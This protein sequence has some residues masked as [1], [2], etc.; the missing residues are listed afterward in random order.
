MPKI[1]AGFGVGPDVLLGNGHVPVKVEKGYVPR[2][3]LAYPMYDADYAERVDAIKDWLKTITNLQQVGRNGLHRYNNSDHSML[4]AI[5]AV[6]N[7]VNGA[8]HDI[9]AGTA[10]Y[11]YPDEDVHEGHVL[12]LVY[13]RSPL[14][15]NKRN[16]ASFRDAHRENSQSS[17]LRHNPSSHYSLG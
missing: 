15:Q 10:E 14:F 4:T 12:A 3:T 7:I 13:P 11:V 5:R 1:A 9:W 6:D 17:T 8:N 16:C 2:V